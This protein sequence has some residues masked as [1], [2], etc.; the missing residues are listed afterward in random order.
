[1]ARTEGTIT[2]RSEYY[3]QLR[4]ALPDAKI[5]DLKA[6]A[7]IAADPATTVAVQQMQASAELAM[8]LNPDLHVRILVIFRLRI[9]LLP[10]QWT[11]LEQ[12]VGTEGLLLTPSP[13]IFSTSH[14]K[15]L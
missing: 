2:L 3:W 7:A 6:A 9:Y 5:A 8:A 11:L 1:M 12:R 13:S 14:G 4:Q 10:H 15:N